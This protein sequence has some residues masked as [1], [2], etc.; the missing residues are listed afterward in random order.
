M[1][2]AGGDVGA[3]TI[4][5]GVVIAVGVALLFSARWFRRTHRSH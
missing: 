4:Y 3:I 1:T 2:G 5:G